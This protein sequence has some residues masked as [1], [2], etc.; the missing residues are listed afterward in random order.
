M[1]VAGCLQVQQWQAQIASRWRFLGLQG[2]ATFVRLC[3][4]RCGWLQGAIR[5]RF[6]LRDRCAKGPSGACCVP[7]C[8]AAVAG[9][10]V[11]AGCK[12]MAVSSGCKA[13][14]LSSGCVPS[15]TGTCKVPSGAGAGCVTGAQGVPLGACCMPGCKSPLGAVQV[16][17]LQVSGC[18]Q[19]FAR[20]R[21]VLVALRR[22]A[23]RAW[24]GDARCNIWR[25]E[26]FC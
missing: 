9:A 20:C 19:G 21:Q 22:A 24:A 17:C 25:Q 8:N 3:A 14:P 13:R 4:I 2:S 26:L 6:R 1:Q 16:V 23:R 5:R 18:R 15:G 7:G 11:P 12:Q 10:G